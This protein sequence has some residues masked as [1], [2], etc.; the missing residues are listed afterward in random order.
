MTTTEPIRNF[1]FRKMQTETCVYTLI[2]GFFIGFKYKKRGCMG[3]GVG[4]IT[5]L[6]I[7]FLK[8]TNEGLLQ[9]TGIEL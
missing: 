4:D 7:I 9:N 6:G 5:Q 3:W 8:G 2:P 1:K